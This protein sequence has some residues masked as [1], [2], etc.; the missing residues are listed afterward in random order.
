M[1]IVFKSDY[2]HD[3]LYEQRGFQAVVTAGASYKRCSFSLKLFY[4]HFWVPRVIPRMSYK[5]ELF[6]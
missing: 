3:Y 6:C 1:M 4:T 2:K 5:M